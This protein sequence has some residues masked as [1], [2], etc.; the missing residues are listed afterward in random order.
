[1]KVILGGGR[2]GFIN[3]TM[4]DNEGRSGL[5]TDGRNLIDEWLE[6]R[7]K[8]GDA[9][10]IWHKKQLEEI[11]IDKTDYILGLFEHD[12]CKN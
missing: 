9:K 11:D 4:Q 6:E 10:F 1:M 12:H 8:D 2:R 5:R 3:T 7:N